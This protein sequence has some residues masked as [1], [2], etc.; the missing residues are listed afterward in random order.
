MYIFLST[1][2]LLTLKEL[3]NICRDNMESILGDQDDCNHGVW[4]KISILLTW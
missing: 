2:N 1:M 3:S 4:S